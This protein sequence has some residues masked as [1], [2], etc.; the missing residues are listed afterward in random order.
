M[1]E[2]INKII[3][4]SRRNKTYPGATLDQIKHIEIKCGYSLPSGYSELYSTTNGGRL[5]NNE[6]LEID[7]VIEL[8]NDNKQFYLPRVKGENLEVCPYKYGENLLKSSFKVL[9]PISEA[10]DKNVLDLVFVPALCVDNKCNRLGYG[11]GFYDRFLDGFEGVSIIPIPQSL[12]FSD[13]CAD[14]HDVCCS[15]VVTD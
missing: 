3:K 15:G 14:R 11:K 5:F 2:V 13:I 6:L 4:Y 12:I 10:V 8:L 1:I 9:E 7:D